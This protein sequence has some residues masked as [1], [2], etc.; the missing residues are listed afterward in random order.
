MNSSSRRCLQ[1]W[2]LKLSNIIWQRRRTWHSLLL[3]LVVA[4]LLYICLP[5]L[6][7]YRIGNGRISLSK[8][9]LFS[10]QDHLGDYES[11]IVGLKHKIDNNS[12]F[13]SFSHEVAQS[14]LEH[15]RTSE[16]REKC[17]A[18]MKCENKKILIAL[19]S[20]KESTTSPYVCINGR[21]IMSRE[22]NGAGRG[23]NVI[24]L[25]PITGIV[26]HRSED[27][28]KWAPPVSAKMCVPYKLEGLNLP[29][30]P[31]PVNSLVNQKKESFCKSHD[32]YFELCEDDAFSEVLDWSVQPQSNA[33]N[34][35]VSKV[36][37]LV[38]P[39]I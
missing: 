8:N 30:S 28:K 5:E 10:H 17:G 26:L 36:P 19:H 29:K 16:D 31:A 20:G 14:Q 15:I 27:G 39:G 34:E 22:T 38:I 24:V 6:I 23:L 4:W 18:L 32:G 9:S 33:R 3:V 1:F 25:E 12:E 21:V 2:K 7:L 35:N 37:I 11:G 13:L